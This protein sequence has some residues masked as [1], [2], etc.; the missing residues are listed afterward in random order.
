[1]EDGVIRA[2]LRGVFITP[3][4]HPV[5]EAFFNNLRDTLKGTWRTV[6]KGLASSVGNAHSHSHTH[7][8]THTH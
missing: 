1:M 2:D 4:N 6:A 8:R 5:V 3:Q 7:A